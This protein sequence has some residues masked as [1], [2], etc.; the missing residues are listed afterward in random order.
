M[1]K[2]E[3]LMCCAETILP[4][5]I[6]QKHDG[7]NTLGWLLPGPYKLESLNLKLPEPQ[8]N[9]WYKVSIKSITAGAPGWLTRLSPTL[10]QVVVSRSVGS[11]PTSG[12]VLTVQSLE[13]ASESVSPPPSFCAS[14]VRALSLSLPLLSLL[15]SH[16]LSFSL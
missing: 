10:A 8:G 3:A 11:S 16:S 15:H 4:W 12:S 9:T 14:P 1:V 13:P 2:G 7:V 5:N 6:L